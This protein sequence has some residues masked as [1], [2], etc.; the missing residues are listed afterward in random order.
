MKQLA[1]TSQT[2]EVTYILEAPHVSFMS[3]ALSCVVF[4][5]QG[6]LCLGQEGE[7]DL[8]LVRQENTTGKLRVCPPLH[9]LLS[10]KKGNTESTGTGREMGEEPSQLIQEVSQQEVPEVSRME[11]SLPGLVSAHMSS[12]CSMVIGATTVGCPKTAGE[13]PLGL[14][15]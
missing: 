13:K 8:V 15:I 1:C 3:K 14:N 4:L 9:A 11:P 6:N 7:K 10:K 5:P 2:S 12:N